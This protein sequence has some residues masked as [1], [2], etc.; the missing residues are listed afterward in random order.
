MPGNLS[1]M[2]LKLDGSKEIETRE[3][4]ESQKQE[5]SRLNCDQQRSKAKK[6]NL[7]VTQ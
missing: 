7:D 3:P 1:Y 4:C 5:K 2:N 6:T